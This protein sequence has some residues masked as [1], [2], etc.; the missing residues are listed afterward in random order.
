MY[1][2]E[3]GGEEE[4][5]RECVEEGRKAKDGQN[6]RLSSVS[7]CNIFL[8]SFRSN[9]HSTS[10]LKREKASAE[11]D[12]KIREQKRP[13][14]ARAGEATSAERGPS[15]F[16]TRCPEKASNGAPTRAE[17]NPKSEAGPVQQNVSRFIKET[18]FQTREK[19]QGESHLSGGKVRRARLHV[20]LPD[21]AGAKLTWRVP[22]TRPIFSRFLSSKP[23][24]EDTR[25]AMVNSQPPP[26]LYKV[27]NGGVPQA[28]SEVLRRVAQL[29][30]P[31]NEKTEKKRLRKKPSG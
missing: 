24:K 17:R 13:G 5:E 14:K 16:R 30:L 8:L 1:G 2:D 20:S 31:L 25:L 15:I 22:P 27:Q 3:K 29:K 12:P 7:A 19:K 18:I 26:F 6:D 10:T 4:R 11:Q 28:C 23:Q 9:R 21:C